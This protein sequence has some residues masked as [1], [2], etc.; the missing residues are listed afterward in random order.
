MLPNGNI[1]L[2]AFPGPGAPPAGKRHRDIG[3]ISTGMDYSGYDRLLFEHLPD[4]VLL[5]TMNRPEVYNA[6]D[7]AMHT[8]LARIWTDISRDDQTRAV[9]ITGAGKAFSAGGDLAMVARQAAITSA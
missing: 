8:Q 2:A 4:G 3:L 9:V 6:A 1:R 5:I 7:E